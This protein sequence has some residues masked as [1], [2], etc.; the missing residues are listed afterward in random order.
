MFKKIRYVSVLKF[1]VLYERND[2]PEFKLNCRFIVHLLS[3][4]LL[5]FFNSSFLELTSFLKYSTL[6]SDRTL[7][8]NSN[9]GISVFIR[10][11]FR[12]HKID[13][14]FLVTSAPQVLIASSATS[15]MRSLP[16][17]GFNYLRERSPHP[18]CNLRRCVMQL[19]KYSSHCGIA[20][21]K[22]INRTEEILS[23]PL[24]RINHATGASLGMSSMHP[25]SA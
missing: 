17:F 7:I 18:R 23:S 1:V 14:R 4:A 12:F 13:V 19:A 6:H 2:N 22:S 9:G 5:W 20:R 16:A 10:A 8:N 21:N 24:S 11:K 3:T 15:N 25:S